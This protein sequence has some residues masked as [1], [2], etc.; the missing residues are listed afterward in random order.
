MQLLQHFISLMGF[1]IQNSQKISLFDT[2]HL[3]TETL[4]S[5]NTLC[6]M[7]SADDSIYLWDWLPGFRKI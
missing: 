2:I 1:N 7:N 6:A 3:K 5:L 4:A